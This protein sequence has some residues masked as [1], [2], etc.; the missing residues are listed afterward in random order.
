MLDTGMLNGFSIFEIKSQFP[1][2]FQEFMK[3]P[4]R[5]RVPGGES[6][7]DVVQRHSPLS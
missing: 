4:F 1:D 2:E 3:D 7:E 5:Y 6:F